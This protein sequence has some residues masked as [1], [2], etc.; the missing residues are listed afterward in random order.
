MGYNKVIIKASRVQ[1][2]GKDAFLSRDG[3]EI[4]GVG[5]HIRL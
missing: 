2:G 3:G 5:V 4:H 1:R